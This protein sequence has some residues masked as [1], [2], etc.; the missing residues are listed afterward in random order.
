VKVLLAGATGAIGR[1]LVPR[2]VAAGHD[3]VALTR[4]AEKLDALTAAGA[5]ARVCDVSD[6]DA[7]LR[8]AR[9]VGPDVV[10]DETTDLPQRYDPR[11]I[12]LFYKGMA[13]LR[14]IG[15]PN[16]MDAALLEDARF[17]FQSIAFLHQPGPGDRLRTE[18]DP[19]FLDDVPPP[20][21]A[22]LPI[23]AG[24][25]RRT[26]DR[27]GTVLRYGFFRGPHTHLAPGGQIHDDIRARRMPIIGTGGG[28][29][30]FVHVDDAAEATVR[31][32]DWDGDGILQVVDDEPIA[33]RDWIPAFARELGAKPPLRVPAWIARRVAGPLAVHWS[34]TLR[35]ASNARAKAELGWTP[36][37]RS[38]RDGFGSAP[39]RAPVPAAAR[40]D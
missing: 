17:V 23:I 9:E 14:L 21:D 29:F 30:S 4:R 12:D 22:A 3:V 40:H 13:P 16:L 35:G 34:T 10:L 33:A 39:V 32:L 8:I 25:E 37:H 5:D 38:V 6:R 36:A 26:V 24:L 11:R 27:G 20:W 18:E 31:A 7:L 28:V 2:L 1:P 19:P 15:T